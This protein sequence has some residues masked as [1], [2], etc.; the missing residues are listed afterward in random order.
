MTPEQLTPQPA[1]CIGQPSCDSGCATTWARSNCTAQ[2]ISAQSSPEQQWLWLG[3]S[4]SEGF[5]LAFLVVLPLCLHFTSLS[6]AS[7]CEGPYVY[8]TG[9]LQRT[10]VE[11]VS[12]LRNV[13]TLSQVAI[14]SFSIIFC[15]FF[16]IHFLKTFPP[17]LSSLVCFP[18]FH[19][20]LQ[21]SPRPGHFC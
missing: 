12:P 13:K 2:N 15:P 7:Q 9:E 4:L 10:Q 8:G 20:P 5:F 19:T 14:L 1:G 21:G 18:G 17:S 3:H 6:T 16:P 11:V